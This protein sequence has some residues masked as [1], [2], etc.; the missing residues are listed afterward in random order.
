MKK[1]MTLGDNKLNRGFTVAKV[2]LDKITAPFGEDREGCPHKGTDFG[3]SGKEKPFKAGVKGKVVEPLGGDWGTIAV[4]PAHDS[5]VTIQYLHCS[6][7]SVKV[8][9]EVTKDTVLG[10]TG[11]KVPAGT[12]I[13]GIHLH[14]QVFKN[15]AP[16]YACWGTGRNFIDP[17]TWD[18]GD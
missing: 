5:T 3:S 12:D 18:T 16:D 17:E 9:A 2:G 1:Q 14:L 15:E 7:I 6:S 11:K 4:K 13:S 10:K 8:G